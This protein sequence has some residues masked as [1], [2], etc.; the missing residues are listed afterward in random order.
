MQLRR[1]QLITEHVEPE[2]VKLSNIICQVAVV[3][4]RQTVWTFLVPPIM[5]QMRSFIIKADLDTVVK[6]RFRQAWVTNC[7]E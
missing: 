2:S 7:G 5:N 4:Y 3:I 6:L 1:N